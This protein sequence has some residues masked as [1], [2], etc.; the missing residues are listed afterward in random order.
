MANT[1]TEI[2]R[3]QQVK[4]D[5]N[6]TIDGEEKKAGEVIHLTVDEVKLYEAHGWINSK[7]GKQ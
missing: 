5:C 1:E 4:L 7:K 2:K 6:C 3:D